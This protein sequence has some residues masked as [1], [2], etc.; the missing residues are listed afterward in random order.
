MNKPY[1]KQY[2]E[3]GTVSNPLKVNFL[4]EFPNDNREQRRSPK[5]KNRFFGNGKNIPLIV[6]KK[7]KYR[8]IMQRAFNL[9]TNELNKIEHY[10]LIK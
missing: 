8:K 1:V 9:K 2:N 6:G 7:Y 5:Q 10:I 4:T 3:D